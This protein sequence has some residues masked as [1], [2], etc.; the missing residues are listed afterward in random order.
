MIDFLDEK[1]SNM[2]ANLA[3]LGPPGAALGLLGPP[4]APL[5]LLGFI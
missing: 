4:G 5:G 3:L 1:P 2:G